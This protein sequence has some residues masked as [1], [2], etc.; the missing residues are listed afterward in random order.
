MFES[1]ISQQK[2]V[3]ITAKKGDPLYWNQVLQAVDDTPKPMVIQEVV[4]QMDAKSVP[5]LL[6][7]FMN[8]AI[9]L[10]EGN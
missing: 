1:H 10:A 3:T 7:D 4:Q 2:K 8:Q 6:A 5:K 9:K